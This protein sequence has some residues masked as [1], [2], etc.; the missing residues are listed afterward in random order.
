MR[1]PGEVAK[2]FAPGTPSHVSAGVSVVKK[3]ISLR[4]KRALYTIN[5]LFGQKFFPRNFAEF[6]VLPILT[7]R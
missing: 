3:E 4:K 2:T 7:T 5:S 6:S 1:R